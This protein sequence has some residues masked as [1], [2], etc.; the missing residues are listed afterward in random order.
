[1]TDIPDVPDYKSEITRAYA[2]G[3][4][5]AMKE[6]REPPYRTEDNYEVVQ[7]YWEGHVRTSNNMK[8]TKVK[9]IP[10]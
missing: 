5:D 10:R 2:K 8:V 6:V 3:R 9:R 4:R 1:M 7:S